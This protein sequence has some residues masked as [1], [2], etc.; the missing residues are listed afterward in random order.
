MLII[1]DRSFILAYF[2]CTVADCEDLARVTTR[3]S[4]VGV[5]AFVVE[6]AWYVLEVRKS[7]GIKGIV[8]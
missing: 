6:D 3:I 4:R 2:F 7:V 5:F 8:R 1:D